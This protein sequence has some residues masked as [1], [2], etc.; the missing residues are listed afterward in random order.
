MKKVAVVTDSEAGFSESELVKGLYVVKMPFIIDG[1]E[2]YEGVNITV[3]EFYN[4]LTSDVKISTSQPSYE[5][6]TNVWKEALQEYDEVVYIPLSSSLSS[7]CS[8]AKN[9]AAAEFEG[10]VYVVDNKRVSVTQKASV[11]EAL[12]MAKKG[13]S[14]AEIQKYLEDTLTDNSIYITIP[15]LKY[16]KRGGR[17]TPAAAA[18][19]TLLQIKPILQIQG[20]KLDTYAK[21][22][23]INQAKQ[24]MIG[25]IK[26]DIETRFMGL[27]KEG[28]LILSMAHTHNKE[29][30][31][32]FKA[33]L[34]TAIPDLEIK[35]VDELSLSVACHIGPGSL[36]VTVSRI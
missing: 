17:V 22:M 10:K 21:V 34:H 1:K 27:K 9:Y 23:N 8:L 29:A 3:D 31:E 15:T 11:I 13:K 33:E 26:K 4:L 28:K 5:E 16:L 25:A 19:G 36:A 35:W 24:R 30:I 7:S 20:G 2:Y 6:V 14:G 32:K 18:L 12:N